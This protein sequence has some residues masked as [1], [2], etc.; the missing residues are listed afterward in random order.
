MTYGDGSWMVCMFHGGQCVFG[1]NLTGFTEESWQASSYIGTTGEGFRSSGE[2]VPLL[3]TE[4]NRINIKWKD[5]GIKLGSKTRR[6]VLRLLLLVLFF[7]DFHSADVYECQVPTEFLFALYFIWQ[8]IGGRN[9][10]TLW[11]PASTSLRLKAR[12]RNRCF[13]A[14][15]WQRPPSLQPICRCVVS[16]AENGCGGGGGGGNTKKCPKNAQKCGQE[17]KGGTV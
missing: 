12:K 2:W 9:I 13:L 15:W 1:W 10:S 11:C 8:A 4:F 16:A 6:L 17:K 14:D 5:L 7:Y 3:T